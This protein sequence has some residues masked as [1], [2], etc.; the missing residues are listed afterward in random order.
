MNQQHRASRTAPPETREKGLEVGEGE[1]TQTYVFLLDHL[2][3]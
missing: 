3:S 2:Q 1:E